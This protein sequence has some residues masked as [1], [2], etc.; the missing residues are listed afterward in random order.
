M[1]S[2][3][4]S[5]VIETS[6]ID[7]DYVVAITELIELGFK[8]PFSE[9]RKSKKA[10]MKSQLRERQIGSYNYIIALEKVGR[11]KIKIKIYYLILGNFKFNQTNPDYRQKVV[12]DIIMAI[13]YRLKYKTSVPPTAFDSQLWTVKRDKNIN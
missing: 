8:L 9:E 12:D 6:N 11:D 7:K 3:E 10:L 5:Y 1:A 13:E 4:N 2:K